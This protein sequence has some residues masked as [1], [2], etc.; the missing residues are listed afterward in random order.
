M[1]NPSDNEPICD[2]C[3]KRGLAV[4]P[5]RYAMSPAKAATPKTKALDADGSALPDLGETAHYTRRLLRPGYLYVHD[6]ARARWEGYFIT[7]YGHLMKFQVGKPMPD[8]YKADA[9]PCSRSGHFEIAGM[10]TVSDPKNATNIWFGYSDVEWTADV[11]SKHADAGYRKKHMQVLDVKA[12][13]AGGTQPNVHAMQSELDKKVAEYALS[14]PAAKSDFAGAPFRFSARRE[15]LK[16]TL[17]KSKKLND[18]GG[19]VISL[20][21]PV[22]VAIEVAAHMNNLLEVQLQLAKSDQTSVRKFAVAEQIRQL[23]MAVHSN[24]ESD[25]LDKATADSANAAAAAGQGAIFDKKLQKDIAASGNIS[26]K[27]ITEAQQS[28]WRKYTHQENGKARFNET[29]ADSFYVSYNEKLKTF[30]DAKI[31]PLGKA[32]VAWTNSG[33]MQSYLRCNFDTKDIQSGLAYLQVVIKFTEGTEGIK[34]CFAQYEKWANAEHFDPAN[35]LMRALVLNQDKLAEQVKEAT[36]FD[37]KAIPWDNLTSSF[38][39]ALLKLGKGHGDLLTVLLSGMAGPFAKAIG[40]VLDGAARPVVIAMG[41]I[42]GG[43]WQ[44]ITLKGSSKDARQ[45]ITRMVVQMSAPTLNDA[46]IKLAVDREIRLA[47]IR[48][49]KMQGQVSMG[50]MIWN[51]PQGKAKPSLRTPLTF[52]EIRFESFKKA[53]NTEVRAGVCVSLVQAWCLTKTIADYGKALEGD[54]SEAGWRLF[55]GSLAVSGTLIESL[56]VVMKNAQEAQ[57][58]W[59]RNLIK[60]EWV[61][62][63]IVG[64]KLLGL[65]GGVI[66]G[67]WDAMKGWEELQKKNTNIAV[68]Y[69]ASAGFGIGAAILFT[70][71]IF[72]IFTLLVVAAFL[73][74]AYFLEQAKS[75]AIQSWLENTI[76]GCQNTYKDATQELKEYKLAIS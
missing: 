36:A 5:V 67:V 38:K 68:L 30:T 11:L 15:F 35:A 12:A 74:A 25:R 20:H 39:E 2:F 59:A 47:Q 48:G 41:M 53:I 40:A 10:V 14:I 43:G 26:G 27:D 21:D 52:N 9:M 56:G 1:A 32:H 18:S 70:A 51:D 19:V 69:F 28:A 17:E 16:S 33:H 58:P 29:E 66:M 44:R 60:I 13:L 7:L 34:P 8:S 75:N 63:T 72:N 61:K 62:R 64:G 76:F 71:G 23:R 4:L 46:Q 65:A 37:P 73:T 57:L 54:K 49:E 22:G 55:A 42:H 3:D 31:N 24:A 50:W 6:E 45:L